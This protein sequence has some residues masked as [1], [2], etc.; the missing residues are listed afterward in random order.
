MLE[1]RL[2]PSRREILLPDYTGS[3]PNLVLGGEQLGE[4][5]SYIGSYTSVESR[6]LEEVSSWI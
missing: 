6:I 5:D 1:V 3:K 2:P 4:V